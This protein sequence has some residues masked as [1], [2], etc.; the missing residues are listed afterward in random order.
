[1]GPSLGL[2]CLRIMEIVLHELSHELNVLL[3]TFLHQIVR[4]GNEWVYDVERA[5]R[6]THIQEQ[7]VRAFNLYRKHNVPVFA[8]IYI[9]ISDT[10]KKLLEIVLII[11]MCCT[12]HLF[13][14][15]KEIGIKHKRR[16]MLRS[17]TISFTAYCRELTLLQLLMIN[18]WDVSIDDLLVEISI[19]AQAQKVFLLND[20]VLRFNYTITL[21]IRFN[22]TFLEYIH[23]LL[24]LGFEHQVP[25]PR[26]IRDETIEIR[27]VS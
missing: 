13:Q 8:Q 17:S 22:F 12:S 9:P 15:W 16:I 18:K 5:H 27:L 20:I 11:F 1:M 4:V 3:L 23:K 6:Q 26:C 2:L 24:E 7:P 21:F 10:T 19:L 25:R 14:F